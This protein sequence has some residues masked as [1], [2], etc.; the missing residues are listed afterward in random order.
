MKKL[1]LLA[2]VL[3]ASCLAVTVHLMPSRASRKSIAFD[4]D[5]T[6]VKWDPFSASAQQQGGLRTYRM[7]DTEQEGGLRSFD[8]VPGTVGPLHQCR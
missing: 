3:V 4:V 7:C 1:L 2:I 8:K 5:L 6:P